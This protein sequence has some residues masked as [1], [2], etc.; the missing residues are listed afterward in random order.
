MAT[1]TFLALVGMRL[2][3]VSRAPSLRRALLLLFSLAL[4]VRYETFLTPLNLMNIMRQNSMLAIVTLGMTVVILSGESI[5]PWAPSLLWAA[6]SNARRTGSL[7]AIVGGIA[8][9]TLL[10]VVNGL[11]VPRE[12]PAVRCYVIHRRA[13][14]GAGISPRKVDCGII[15]LG[16]CLAGQGF[17]VPSLSPCYGCAPVFRSLVHA[18]QEPIRVAHVRG[19]RQE[20][21]AHGREPGRVK[22][23]PTR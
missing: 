6:S 23:W 18:A 2:K 1:T 5:S 11:R 7:V 12:A 13:L 16:T 9:A 14:R 3:S 15:S 21:P 19:R 4:I 22:L 20:P 17:M 8:S 10:G